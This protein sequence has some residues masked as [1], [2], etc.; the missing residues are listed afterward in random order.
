MS[1]GFKRWSLGYLSGTCM[2]LSC[3]L[4][5]A[6]SD[7]WIPVA[8]IGIAFYFADFLFEEAK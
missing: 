3:G 6:Q 1:Y 4:A 5:S 7:L 8:G 2:G